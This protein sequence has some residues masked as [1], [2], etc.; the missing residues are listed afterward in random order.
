MKGNIEQLLGGPLYPPIPESVE[1][2]IREAMRAYSIDPPQQIVIDGQIHRF[3]IGTSIDAGWYVLYPDGIVAGTFGNWKDGSSYNWHAK[4]GRDLTPAEQMRIASRIAEAKAKRESE[5]KEKHERAADTVSEIWRSNGPSNEEHP[6]L[7]LKG[8]KPHG[9]RITGDGRLIVPMYVGGELSSLQYIDGEGGKKYHAGG[10]TKGAVYVIGETDNPEKIYIAEGFATAATVY[11][12]TNVTTVTAFSAQMLPHVAESMREH[13]PSAKLVIVADNDVSGTGANYAYQA[14]AKH[15]AT[16]VMPPDTGDVNDMRVSGADVKSLLM[17]VEKKWLIPLDD[18]IRQPAPINWLV[19][20][21][22]QDDAL[23]MVHGA[24][25]SGKTFLVLDWCMSIAYGREWMGCRTKQGPIAYLAGEGHKGLMKRFAGWVA[26]NGVEADNRVV[27]SRSGTDLD[28]PHGLMEV[29]NH[30]R[31]MEESPSII[32]IDTLHRFLSGDENRAQDTRAMLQSCAALMDEFSCSVM[33][34]H[35]TGVA[36]DAQRR[37]RG[38]S[39]WKGALDIEVSVTK[40]KNDTIEVRCTKSK[41][42]REPS[43][44]WIDLAGIDVPGWVNEDG[45]IETTAIVVAGEK[46]QTKEKKESPTQ[47]GSESF[48]LAWEHT[49]A[50]TLDGAPYITRS[51]WREVLVSLE[52]MSESSA[53]KALQISQDRPPIYM[54]SMVN[55][56]LIEQKEAGFIAINGLAISLKS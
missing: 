35:H 20:G 26:Y 41:D 7:K 49:G 39:A 40:G 47:I 30:L 10:N 12:E 1:T 44:V 2:Q 19:K 21:W 50:E 22:I 45:D 55:A 53:K 29:M 37:A 33:L 18:F 51:A 5:K 15:G 32:V 27:V 46:P 11:E 48:R 52:G 13:Y 28:T 25:G 42:D 8:V 36:Q 43:P 16:V 24:P 34:V 9:T 54:E 17:P 3:P 23:M 31:E 4:P 56:E 38:S 14:A 6:Y